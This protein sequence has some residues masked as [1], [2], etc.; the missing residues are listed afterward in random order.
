VIDILDFT[1]RLGPAGAKAE[2]D[3]S[4]RDLPWIQPLLPTD[5]PGRPQ[6]SSPFI[7]ACALDGPGCTRFIASDDHAKR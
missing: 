3:K 1:R 2:I 4:A 6:P 7:V 5:P